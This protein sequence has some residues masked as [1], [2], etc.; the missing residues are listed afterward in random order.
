MRNIRDQQKTI[1]SPGRSAATI[2]VEHF[3]NSLISNQVRF[4]RS[5][6]DLQCTLA[7]F[8]L[9]IVDCLDRISA[10]LASQFVESKHMQV[11]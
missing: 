1:P 8:Y 3:L 10:K 11:L 2:C 5:V 9:V 7:E 4:A 6:E